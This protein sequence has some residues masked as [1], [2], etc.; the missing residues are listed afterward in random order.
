MNSWI[1]EVIPTL[2][3]VIT[4][5]ILLMVLVIFLIVKFHKKISGIEERVIELEKS[6]KDNFSED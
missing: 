4:F 6:I 3:L 1:S 5:Y 2:F